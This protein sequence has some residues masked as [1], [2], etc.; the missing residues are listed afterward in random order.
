M[1]VALVVAALAVLVVGAVVWW[2][3]RPRPMSTVAA[4][5]VPWD[6]DAGIASLRRHGDVL[7]AVSPVWFHPGDDG[8]LV[9][10]RDPG[11]RELIAVADAHDV[12]VVPAITNHRD[13]RWDADL[14]HRL[15]ADPERRADHVERIVA[16]VL[17][18]DFAGVDLDYEALRPGDRD[19]YAAFVA[20]LAEALHAHDRTLSVTVQP[21]TSDA[22]G[23]P[24]HRAQ[25]YTALGRA[26]DQVRVMIYDQHG[27][28]SQ[29]GPL[30][31]IGWTTDV[32]EY[33]VSRIPAHKV[34]VGIGAYGYDWAGD[35]GWD[36][37]WREAVDL[38]AHHD[39]PLHWDTDHAAPFFTYADER[40]V[41][42]TV[43]FE[44]AASQ[45][46]K[47]EVARRH[48]VGGVFVWRL[49][50]EPPGLWEDLRARSTSERRG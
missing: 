49:G 9:E 21:K 18:R 5:V 24:F 22:G 34:V 47:V 38:A 39:A 20:E 41:V 7:T 6:A 14:V 36:L 44:N 26:A 1:T 8:G 27:P 42:H 19:A 35:G 15:V 2:V 40:D 16:L 45:L 31:S 33:A 29:P 28:W 46:A 12:A 17:R 43:W 3:Q 13:G 10:H 4:Y 11:L 30:A 37:M 23:A 25:D 50:G 48:G 32:I